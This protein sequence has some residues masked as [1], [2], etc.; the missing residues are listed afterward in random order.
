MPA[1]GNLAGYYLYKKDPKKAEEVYRLAIQNNPDSPI[2][3]LRL[4][5][6][7]LHEN[8]KA[9]G[10]LVIQQLRDKQPTSADVALAIGD[11]YLA[12]RNTEGAIKEYQRGLNY[13]PKNSDLQVRLLETYVNTGKIEDAT[14]MTDSMLKEKPGDLTA[15]MI[16]ARLLAIKGNSAEAITTLRDVVHDAPDNAQAHFMLGQVLRQ[17]RRSAGSQERVARGG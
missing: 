8:R 10:E 1:Y 7:M 2:P 14:K 3:Y 9:D 5:G 15:R 11:Y 4:A 13:D 6:L 12:S 16:H 17:I